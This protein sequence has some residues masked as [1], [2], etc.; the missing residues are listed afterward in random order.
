MAQSHPG[1]LVQIHGL[2]SEAGQRLNGC[3]GRI[4]G[5]RKTK[6]GRYRVRLL[7]GDAKPVAV[8]PANLVDASAARAAGTPKQ[9]STGTPRVALVRV[10]V[11]SAESSKMP[12]ECLTALSQ[13]E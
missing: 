10:A 1:T 13:T 3:Y 2:T 11:V 7:S 6:S 5:R 12:S 9:S 8:L 4:H